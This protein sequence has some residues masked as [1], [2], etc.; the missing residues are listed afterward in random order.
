MRN[1]ARATSLVVACSLLPSCEVIGDVLGSGVFCL[2][3]LLDLAERTRDDTDDEIL[4]DLMKT[5]QDGIDG[6]PLFDCKAKKDMDSFLGTLR[7]DTDGTDPD[8][9]KRQRKGKVIEVDDPE[10]VPDALEEV[11]DE[12]PGDG[13]DVAVLIDTTGSIWDDY[14]AINS[15][16]DRILD[17]VKE[18]N[19]RV[20]IAWY[21]DN[22]SCDTPWYGV[23]PSGLVRGGSPEITDFADAMLRNGLVGGCDI[24]ESMYDGIAETALGLDWTSADRTIV[25]ITDAGA[26]TGTGPTIARATWPASSTSERPRWTSSSPR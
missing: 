10:E 21:G 19:G 7:S 23:N 5:Y 17:T 12:G 15:E 9:P 4:A 6:L 13:A 20:S 1:V 3:D 24:P 22:Q 11:V 2:G 26:L 14:D 8:L 16:L 18:K 25:V